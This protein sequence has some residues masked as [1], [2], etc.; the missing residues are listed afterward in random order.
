MG[1]ICGIGA[2]YRSD[3]KDNENELDFYLFGVTA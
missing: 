2:Q 1:L 3:D